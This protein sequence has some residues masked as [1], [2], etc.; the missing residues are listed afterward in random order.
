MT[1]K[2]HTTKMQREKERALLSMVRSKMCCRKIAR[3]SRQHTRSEFTQRFVVSWIFGSILLL[4]VPIILFSFSCFISHYFKTYSHNNRHQQQQQ[5]RPRIQLCMYGVRCL[6]V[7]VCVAASA[8]TQTQIE[9]NRRQHYGYLQ[10]H[11][12]F[13]VRPNTFLSLH[14]IVYSSM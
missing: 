3:T 1:S 8:Y 2:I 10:L 9:P 14:N 5:R 13:I 11:R 7:C 12:H 6:C 4:P